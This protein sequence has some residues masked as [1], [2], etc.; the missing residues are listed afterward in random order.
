MSGFADIQSFVQ[1]LRAAAQASPVHGGATL[2]ATPVAELLA[3]PPAE[4]M[5]DALAGR[6]LLSSRDLVAVHGAE[7]IELAG[8]G[9]RST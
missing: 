5:F 6:L 9:E 1:R 4:K 8:H 2:L 7:P 3:K